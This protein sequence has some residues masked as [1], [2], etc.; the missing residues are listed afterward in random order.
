MKVSQPNGFLCQLIEVRGL[1]YWVS[2][3]AEIAVSLVVGNDEDDI[4]IGFIC[5]D[6]W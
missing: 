2:G 5:M 3:E 4:R 6:S 1:Y